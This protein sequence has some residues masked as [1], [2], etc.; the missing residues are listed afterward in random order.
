MQLEPDRTDEKLD[1][2]PAAPVSRAAL[3]ARAGKLREDHVDVPGLGKVLVR[4]LSGAARAKLIQGQA[5]ASRTGIPDVQAYQKE[6]LLNGLIDPDSPED[7]RQ[8]LLEKADLDTVMQ[9]GASAIDAL[10]TRI[11]QLSG[12][13]V[14]VEE[15]VRANF[16]EIPNDDS[17]SE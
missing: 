4:E 17:T 2:A 10:C 15:L 9:L 13:S 12:L 16:P 5:Q 14:D 1:K 11:E 3:L 7:A 6:L 8:P